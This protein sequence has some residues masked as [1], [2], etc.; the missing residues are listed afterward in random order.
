M[1]TDTGDFLTF[2]QDLRNSNDQVGVDE[3]PLPNLQ[4][5]A[6]ASKSPVAPEETRPIDVGGGENLV[7][8]CEAIAPQKANSAQ[9]DQHKRAVAVLQQHVAALHTRCVHTRRLLLCAIV[10]LVLL[11]LVLVALSL[12]ILVVQVEV[13]GHKRFTVT[14]KVRYTSEE[15]TG[16]ALD[17][18]GSILRRIHEFNSRTWGLHEERKLHDGLSIAVCQDG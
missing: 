11:I 6:S 4:S 17:E 1:A 12:Y 13:G 8:G 18:F 5:G 2:L 7:Q 10:L 9:D 3:A 14:A 16:G 15:Y